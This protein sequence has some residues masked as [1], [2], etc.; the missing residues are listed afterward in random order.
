MRAYGGE[1][2]ALLRQH[3]LLSTP[4]PLIR[5]SGTFSPRE[6]GIPLRRLWESSVRCGTLADTVSSG[7]MEFLVF[8]LYVV[9]AISFA[10]PIGFMV[11][12]AVAAVITFATRRF[13][14]AILYL[15]G[16]A[17][18]FI[19]YGFNVGA[20]NARIASREKMI[21]ALPRAE[22]KGRYPDTFVV[23]GY[24]TDLELG[25]LLFEFDFNRIHM[26]QSGEM[27]G[28]FE[29][30]LLERLY[31]SECK[32]AAEAVLSAW[33]R[34]IRDSQFYRQEVKLKNCVLV[35]PEKL[36]KDEYPNEAVVLLLDLHT[37]L[38]S[39]NTTWA[40]GNIEVRLQKDGTST[41]VDYWERLYASRQTSPFCLPF[42]S[43]CTS[44]DFNRDASVGRFDFLTAALGR[45]LR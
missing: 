9:Q 36:A 24:L 44:S 35:T 18:P 1:V 5:P 32:A 4:Y 15:I 37:T 20:F 43:F 39:G 33:R 42:N 17:T 16:M 28:R 26:F 14:L 23:H 40:G 38:R 31:S 11:F 45:P 41:L 29:G 2:R 13:F 8:L 7:V 21:E 27:F 3:F 22:L 25:V 12:C 6:K 34:D 10:I 30:Q 19:A